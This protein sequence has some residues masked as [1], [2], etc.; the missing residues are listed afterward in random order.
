MTIAPLDPD[1]LPKA[2][3]HQF[4][5]NFSSAEALHDFLK[6]TVAL[7]NGSAAILFH[8]NTP[9]PT[10]MN[11]LISRQAQQWSADIVSEMQQAA[12][13][14]IE[15][16]KTVTSRLANYE[17]AVIIAV[18]P[19]VDGRQGSCL[20]VVL[21]PGNLPMQ[22]FTTTLQLLAASLNLWQERSESGAVGSSAQELLSTALIETL[23]QKNS[24]A[25]A[26]TLA[27][28]LNDILRADQVV[29][30]VCQQN[31]ENARIIGRSSPV[32]AHRKATVMQ[33]LQQAASESATLGVTTGWPEIS[34]E[35]GLCSPIARSAA[36]ALN[37]QLFYSRPFFAQDN[38]VTGVL[39]V[40][41]QDIPADIDYRLGL[42]EAHQRLIAGVLSWL[43]HLR[44]RKSRAHPPWYRRRTRLGLLLGSILGL[45]VLA[46][47]PVPFAVKAPCMIAPQTVRFAVA[48]FDAIVAEVFTAAGDQVRAQQHLAQLDGRLIQLE[49]GSLQAQIQQQRKLQDVRL[50]SKQAAAAQLARL[51]RQRL[52]E[53]QTLLKERLANLEIRAPI[54]GTVIHS[55]LEG[56]IGAPVRRGQVLFEIAPL[57]QVSV[58]IQ[59]RQEDIAYIEPG[60]STTLNLVAFPGR[61]WQS[62]I[63]RID[64]RAVIKQGR[65]IFEAHVNLANSEALLRPGMQG[66]ASV[67]AGKRPL[68]WVLLREPINFLLRL[69][70]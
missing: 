47:V 5:R 49:V 17:S 34:E 20:V 51:E 24:I 45:V 43:S 27:L 22:V 42:L 63:T 9:E 26:S 64:P 11:S 60:A 16:G 55:E 21:I 12:C 25:G 32:V 1:T 35:N 23:A 19:Q 10:V 8:N 70:I 53:Q 37:A 46:W 52:E 15:S 58:E 14:A 48:G 18:G 50:A 39:L 69:Q 28:Q 54:A 57:E 40:A 59:V 4:A 61:T 66:D 13:A 44:K 36:A 56:K 68:W 38:S 2:L 30:A 6:I 7:V 67:V 65:N 41:W 31:P 33:I 62:S 29:L 3:E